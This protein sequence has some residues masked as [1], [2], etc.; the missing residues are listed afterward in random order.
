MREYNGEYSCFECQDLFSPENTYY[1]KFQKLVSFEYSTSNPVLW[2]ACAERV[3]VK[4]D[5]S[6]TIPALDGLQNRP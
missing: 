3:K 1:I 6:Q 2:G 4:Q 5:V